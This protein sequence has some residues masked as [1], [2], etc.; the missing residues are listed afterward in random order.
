MLV[1]APFSLGQWRGILTWRSNWVF[2]YHGRLIDL[3]W[4]IHSYLTALSNSSFLVPY[5]QLIRIFIKVGVESFGVYP[6]TNPDGMPFLSSGRM[7]SSNQSYSGAHP[8][9]SM[10]FWEIPPSTLERAASC[11][12]S[13]PDAK[14]C[15][16]PSH[17]PGCKCDLTNCIKWMVVLVCRLL[18]GEYFDPEGLH[19]DERLGLY[20]KFSKFP[21]VMVLDRLDGPCELLSECLREELFNR[22]IELLRKDDC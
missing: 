6:V 13:L 21:I 14:N 15:S 10:W 7:S 1:I 19:A 17:A 2:N 20:L 4:F 11:S 12:A 22:D 18:A 5:A 16:I 8:E 3:I 9:M